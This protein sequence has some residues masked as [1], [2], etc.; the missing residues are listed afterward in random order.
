MIDAQVSPPTGDDEG[1]PS[2]ELQN[3]LL[4]RIPAGWWPRVEAPRGWLAVLNQLDADLA[5]ID[6]Q[7]ELRRAARVDNELIYVTET[8]IGGGAFA[9]RITQAQAALR[10]VCEFCGRAGVPRTR[11]RTVLCDQHWRPLTPAEKAFALSA[12]I[13]EAWFTEES[14]IANRAYLTRCEAADRRVSAAHLS[15]RD[16]AE[17]LNV[18]VNRVH[19]MFE[20]EL[21]AGADRN[22]RVVYPTWQLTD[23]GSLLPGLAAVLHAA[24]DIDARSLQALMENAEEELEGLSPAEW[25]ASGRSVEPVLAL[26]ADWWWT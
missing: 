25:L 6:P 8:A 14:E 26:L 22:G 10:T 15:E 1:I 3:P 19:E 2:L 13:P 9:A 16:I 20:H 12:D 4:A 18:G 21:L 23:D 7:Y 11:S 17:L 5:S 24:D